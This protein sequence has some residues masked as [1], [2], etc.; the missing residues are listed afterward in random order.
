MVGYKLRLNNYDKIPFPGESMD[1]YSNSWVGL[2]LIELGKPVGISNLIG[3]KQDYFAYTNVDRVYQTVASAGP[4]VFHEPWLDHP[5]M[6]G[7]ITGGFAYLK[8]ARV[9]EDAIASLIRKPMI[10]IGTLTILCTVYLAY[11]LAGPYVALLAGLLYAS[12]PLI[13]VSSRMI[14]AENGF[15]PLLLLT[16]VCVFKYEKQKK[17]IFLWLAGAFAALCI[18]FKIPGGVATLIGS[19]ILMTQ[20]HKSNLAKIKE[21]ILF[22]AI[23]AIGFIIFLIYGS[24][25]DFGTFKSI[26]LANSSRIYG[27]GLNAVN[28]LLTITKITGGKI[29]TDG[30]PLLGWISLFTIFSY[31]KNQYFRYLAIPIITYLIVYLFTGSQAYGWYRIPFMPFLFISAASFLYQ[32][33]ALPKNTLMAITLLLIPLGINLQKISE[34]VTSV[35][36]I[37]YW[38][39]GIVGCFLL[40][41]A[42]VIFHNN[43]KTLNTIYKIILIA[44][45]LLA[46]ITNLKYNQMITTDYWYKSS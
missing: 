22:L 26:F 17:E 29:L 13:V 6:L 34:A 27:I 40:V 20:N 19:I 36:I 24:A 39:Y 32:S 9:F 18:T 23:S 33:L 41:L 37:G 12:S 11:L 45:I 25:F 5:P 15:L 30:W 38:R 44:I 2:S 7:L 10:L 1:E 35:N 8:G 3:Y 16:V 43:H 14:Q 42:S 21:S 46:L 28:D 4:L 31:K